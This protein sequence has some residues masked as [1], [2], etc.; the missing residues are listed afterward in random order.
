MQES[1]ED[2]LEKNAEMQKV[3]F[4]ECVSVL[5]RLE[6]DDLVTL[7]ECAFNFPSFDDGEHNKHVPHWI[8]LTNPETGPNVNIFVRFYGVCFETL[9]FDEWNYLSA[10]APR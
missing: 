5:E 4:A 10:G 9:E 7:E 2:W 6:C 1:V 3:M 8:S